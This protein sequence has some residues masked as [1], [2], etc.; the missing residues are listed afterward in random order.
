[1]STLAARACLG[2]AACAWAAAL[3][4]LQAARF[5]AGFHYEW[6]DDALTHQMLWNVG[7]GAFLENTIHPLHRPSHFEGVLVLLWPLYAGL[8][9]LIGAW[10]AVWTLK[11]VLLALA[12]PATFALARGEGAAPQRALLWGLV[13]LVLPGSLALGLSTFRPLALVVAPLVA[14]V[15]TVRAG[16]VG[17]TLLLTLLVLAFREDLALSLVPLGL[18]CAWRRRWGLAG[19]LVGV[20]ALVYLVATRLVLPAVLP[21][22]YEHIVFAQNVGPGLLERATDPSHLIA[23]AALLL[24]VLGLPITV[25]ESVIGAASLGA[26][27]VFKGGFAGNLLHFA[28]PAI[29]ACLVG[30]VIAGERSGGLRWAPQACLAVSAALYLAPGG[31]ALVATDCA[32]NGAPPDPALCTAETPFS[33]VFTRAPPHEAVRR[34]LAAEVPVNASVAAPGHLLPPLSPRETLWEYGHSDVPFATAEYILLDDI[35]RYA[36]A[37]RY[38][39]LRPGTLNAHLSVLAATHDVLRME[40]GVALLRRV[41]PGPDLSATLRALLPR[42]DVAPSERR[43]VRAPGAEKR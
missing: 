26:I 37:G 28:G 24:P 39:A 34:A 31:L 11:A 19:V 22:G 9:A 36:G 17:W 27:L 20:P 38:L 43:G 23:A 12:A 2:L 40:H 25:A 14:L 41:R 5:E 42:R 8:S 4:A 29:A 13:A 32:H 35:D 3:V 16:R 7:R 15:A 6:E 18:L 21:A 10:P 30:A 33:A 1:M